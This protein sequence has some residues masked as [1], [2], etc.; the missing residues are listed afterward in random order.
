MSNTCKNFQNPKIAGKWLS[1]GPPP[2]FSPKI[3]FNKMTQNGLKWI[4]N[5]TLK[6]VT[7]CRPGHWT[8]K[9]LR[10]PTCTG[11]PL[12]C[13]PQPS[14]GQQSHCRGC[15]GCSCCTSGTPWCRCPGCQ[16]S[17]RCG[18]ALW[19]GGSRRSSP[20]TGP[21]PSSGLGAHIGP[22]P[23][24]GAPVSRGRARGQVSGGL[25]DQTHFLKISW[26]SWD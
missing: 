11:Y 10:S 19:R 1:I 13:S 6:S 15:T 8:R 25:R 4:L 14:S 20:C 12:L 7:F 22:A 18:R 23:A 26:F 5:A 2:L 3:F 24:L 16:Q 17:W 9:Q 21:I